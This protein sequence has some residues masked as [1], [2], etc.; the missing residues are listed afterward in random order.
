MPRIRNPEPWLD[1]V[2]AP[3]V[4]PARPH[5]TV[6]FAAGELSRYLYLLTGRPSAVIE[7]LPPRGPAVVLDPHLCRTVGGGADPAAVG[8]QGF[9]L[10]VLAHGR[11]H[12]VTLAGSAPAGV[13]YGAYELLERLG[14][15]FYAGGDTFPE[16][17][18]PARLPARLD[19]TR[20][21]AFSVRGNM[22]HYNFL[23]GCTDWGLSDY[24]FYFDQLARMRCN[25]L[26]MHWYDHEPGAA[27]EV[28]GEYLAGGVTPNSLTKPWGALAALRTSQF[29]F[30]SGRWFD[31]EIYSTPMGEALPDLLTEIRETE[32]VFRLATRYARTA[33]IG[34]AA[35]FEAPNGDP[36]SAAVRARFKARLEQFLARNPDLTHLALWQHESGG[37]FGSTPPRAGTDAARLLES[38][39]ARYAYLGTDRRV[40]EAIRYG[41]FAALAADF[42]AREAPHLRLVVVGW[43]GDRWM[44]FADLCEGYDQA[45]PPSVVF[46]CHDNIDASFGPN[47]STP[48]GELPPQRERWAMPWVEGDI[49]ECWVRQPNVESLGTLAPDALAKGAQGLLTLQWRTRDVEE[50]T[51][52]IARFAWDT[53]LTP[54]RFY[55]R[56]ASH[57]FGPD[58]ERKM[59]RVLGTL[60]RL[61]S[62]WTG[63]RGSGECSR[64][65]WTGHVPHF[66]FTLDGGA[67]AFLLPMVEKA[68]ESLSLVPPDAADPESGAYHL[69]PDDKG[70]G[71]QPTDP[72]RLG[73]A[74]LTEVMDRLR[75]LR[76]QSDPATLRPALRGIEED[77]W[78]LRG[79]LVPYGMSGASY[80]SLDIFLIALH[81]VVRNAGADRKMPLLRRLR[82]RLDALR[83]SYGRS[84]RLARLERLDHL[85]ATM[86]FVL[87]YDA[88]AMLLADGETVERALA[89]AE[90]ARAA[91]NPTGAAAPAADAYRKLL[92]AGMEHAVEALTRKLATRCDFGV[93]ATFNVKALPLY[94]EA[95]ERLEAHLPA[96][97]PREVH[98]RGLRSEVW[99]SW[100][101]SGRAA[102]QN[103]HRRAAEGGAWRRVNRRPLSGRCAAF[104]DRAMPRPGAYE[105]AVTAV[106]EDGW[107]SPRSHTV[108]VGC[109]RHVQPPRLVGAMPPSRHTAGDDLPVRV[110][111]FSDRGLAEVSVRYRIA[112]RNVWKAVPLHPSFRHGYAGRLPGSALGLGTL[113]YYVEARDAEGCVSV[114]PA[115]SRTGLAWTVTVVP[116]C[117]R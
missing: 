64:M 95:V 47:V 43:G 100:A 61:G 112:G 70:T 12:L 7:A 23:C 60:Q 55:R 46:T 37:C 63:V 109:G 16:R 85:A 48:W 62:R 39:R 22:L 76:G 5:E 21:P 27:Y 9:R 67:P 97:P 101:P 18:A 2:G 36:T 87:H 92:A 32:R 74:Q 71:Q 93:L 81:H 19:V 29:A 15:G 80:R 31:A 54:E 33:A 105:Y 69:R 84:G 89:S 65:A 110:V 75:S 57:A 117:R 3:I 34:V 30:G 8:P 116:P 91:G 94:W 20:R 106:A 108:R 96:V 104:V 59:S 40:W 25:M 107:E 41:A 17:P 38:Q 90:A 6:R 14:M 79:R 77:V 11:R 42:L 82:R 114:W 73:V 103:V 78:A 28:G 35:G 10:A 51:G 53:A 1:L 99:L 24:Q 49:D 72:A 45:L 52:Y 50:E 68:V 13:L 86:D 4:L 44:R 26:L 66:P 111:A 58:H 102:A 83:S 115:A 98:A 88:A 113:E 56:L